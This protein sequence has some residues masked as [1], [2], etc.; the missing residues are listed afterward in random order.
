[1]R[2]PRLLLFF[3]VLALA[4][5]APVARAEVTRFEEKSRT[6]IGTSGYEKITGTLHFAVAPDHPRNRPIA[7]LAL[8]PVNSAGR[9]EFSSDL[10]I[11]RPVDPAVANG[12]ALVEVSNRGGKGLLSGFNRGAKSDPATDA[13]L[14]DNFLLRQGFTL[15]WVGWEFD[16][17]PTPGLL[18]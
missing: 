17:P 4:V 12:T 11:L 18:R 13:D 3:A 16:V 10:V 6:A 8:A 9:V 1:M 14:G 2:L 7:D 5:L 15:V